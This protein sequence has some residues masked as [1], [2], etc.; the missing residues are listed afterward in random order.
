MT[1]L[2]GEWHPRLRRPL[3]CGALSGYSSRLE[4]F[5]WETSIRESWKRLDSGK[6][7]LRSE[8]FAG[9]ER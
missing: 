8:V 5:R 4:V 9:S 1:G 6:D 2:V 7:W 3:S